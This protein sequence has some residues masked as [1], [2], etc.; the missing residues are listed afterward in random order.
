MI[1]FTGTR[2]FLL[3]L[4]KILYTLDIAP[5]GSLTEICSKSHRFDILNTTEI[6]VVF[7]FVV[8]DYLSGLRL[9]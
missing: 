2:N 6:N 3:G 1:I 5:D 7:P 4:I 9:K 8:K